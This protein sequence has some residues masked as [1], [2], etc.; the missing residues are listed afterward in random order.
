MA[1]VPN[2][3]QRADAEA[4]ADGAHEQACNRIMAISDQ[5]PAPIALRVLLDVL[6][7]EQVKGLAR[8][9]C[10]D[11]EPERNGDSEVEWN[12]RLLHAIG[13]RDPFELR[14][15]DGPQVCLRFDS[16]AYRVDIFTGLHL[17]KDE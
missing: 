4:K 2:H 9:R 6:D 15:R 11:D 14:A 12:S 13:H 7:R 1:I 10:A 3:V 5:L 17:G 8:D 16:S